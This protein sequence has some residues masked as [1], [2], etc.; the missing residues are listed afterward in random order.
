MSKVTPREGTCL[1]LRLLPKIPQV[2]QLELEWRPNRSPSSSEILHLEIPIQVL[3]RLANQ[4][5]NRL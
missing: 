5:E 1:N 2:W 3:R 4:M